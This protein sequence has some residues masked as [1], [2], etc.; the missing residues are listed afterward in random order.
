MT[1]QKS[2][3]RKVE[4]ECKLISA[5]R[6]GYFENSPERLKI[7]KD[8]IKRPHFALGIGLNFNLDKDIL[9]VICDV[10]FYPRKEAIKNK[11]LF[12]INSRHSFRVKNLKSFKKEKGFRIPDPFMQA[13]I[14][15]SI[16]GARG[17]LA[18]S[19]MNSV[20]KN[21]LIPLVDVNSIL[22]EVQKEVK[23]KQATMK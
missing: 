8:D 9:N 7:S 22:K 3:K 6:T 4:I 19:T 11:K 15:T 10:Y 14:A 5:E 23:N 1:N 12:G 21:I 18:V 17:M 13:L 2:S 20:Y 16:S